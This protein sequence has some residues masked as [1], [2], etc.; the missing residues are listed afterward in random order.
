MSGFQ[1]NLTG[2]TKGNEY[3]GSVGSPTSKG[4]EYSGSIGSP[5]YGG[6]EYMPLGDGGYGNKAPVTNKGQK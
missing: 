5:V 2:K 6:E 1:G 4:N 3:S